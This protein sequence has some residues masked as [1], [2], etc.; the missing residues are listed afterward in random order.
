MIQGT[1]HELKCAAIR[2]LTFSSFS[3]E[4][5]SNK[6]LDWIALC[7]DNEEAQAWNCFIRNVDMEDKH[8]P[9]LNWFTFFEKIL[10]RS[11]KL[12]PIIVEAAKERYITLV[13]TQRS[14]SKLNEEALRLPLAKQP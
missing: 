8:K 6:I 5:E 10:E 2:L 1:D 3:N 9:S 14:E 4:G 7:R 13:V 12:H 11:A